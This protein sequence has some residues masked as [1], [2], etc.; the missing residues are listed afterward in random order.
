[1]GLGHLLQLLSLNKT[2][3][4]L[5]VARGGEKQAIHFGPEG[6]RILSSSVPRVRRLSRLAR[7][8][9]HPRVIAPH[10]LKSLLKREK[11]L[12]WTLGHA[13]L[14]DERLSLEKIQE[15]LRLQVEEEILDLF[16]WENA[17]F[18][19]LEGPPGPA[20]MASPLAPLTIR[21]DVTALLLE[22]T[23]RADEV[24]QIRQ[25]LPDDALKVQKIPREIY[26]DELGEDLIRVDAILPL[27]NGHRTLRSILEASIYPKFATLK[28]VQKLLALGYAKARDR[29]GQTLALSAVPAAP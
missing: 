6:I 25:T 20:H 13:V 5:V 27:I 11:L 19:F 1:V 28:A 2:Q 16:I 7:Q 22:A 21:A 8:L 24:L 14:A 4:V 12:G 26:A 3:G 18:A 17:E 9:S 15:A 29:A 23:R 10:R